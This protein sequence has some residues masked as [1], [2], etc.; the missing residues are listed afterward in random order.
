MVAA[1]SAA[2]FFKNVFAQRAPSGVRLAPR[3]LTSAASEQKQAPAAAATTIHIH[4]S[5]NPTQA[6]AEAAALRVEPLLPRTVTISPSVQ[7]VLDANGDDAAAARILLELGLGSSA[8]P[9]LS[10]DRGSFV[11]TFACAK[12]LQTQLQLDFCAG[13]LLTVAKMR[14]L[15][16]LALSCVSV[17]IRGD[18]AQ[19]ERL[20][21]WTEDRPLLVGRA[22]HVT[23]VLSYWRFS[24]DAALCVCHAQDRSP[25][26]SLRTRLSST[27]CGSR[28][29]LNCFVL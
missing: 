12:Q 22:L 9:T 29:A 16:V 28:T 27:H 10:L 26:M 4:M 6:Q 8:S 25:R 5:P 15:A 14:V 3:V 24:D 18:L 17:V 7:L 1:V 19:V 20:A 11:V 21:E 2:V 23:A 13:R